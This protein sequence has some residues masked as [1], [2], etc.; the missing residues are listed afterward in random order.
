MDDFYTNLLEV[1]TFLV[2]MFQ[3]NLVSSLILFS[4][5]VNL[6]SIKSFKYSWSIIFWLGR[7]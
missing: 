6:A 3:L 7:R 4:H 2:I 5:V 1:V